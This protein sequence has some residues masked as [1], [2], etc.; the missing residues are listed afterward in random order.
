MHSHIFP[1]SVTV[2]GG[3]QSQQHSENVK[4]LHE[5]ISST[6][7]GKLEINQKQNRSYSNLMTVLVCRE[8]EREFL[9][10]SGTVFL[11]TMEGLAL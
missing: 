7:K 1:S 4:I 11:G 8:S 3:S 2:I 5:F 10:G 9:L 6:R